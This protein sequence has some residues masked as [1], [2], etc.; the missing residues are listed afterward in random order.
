M[1]LTREQRALVLQRISVLEAELS[2]LEGEGGGDTPVPA[3]QE[4]ETYPLQQPM[5][6]DPNAQPPK[7][8]LGEAIARG[9]A[10]GL[11][12]GGEPQVAGITSAMNP[13]AGTV[14]PFMNNPSLPPGVLL[15]GLKNKSKEQMLGDYRTT[16]DSEIAANKKAEADRPEGYIP[17]QIATSIASSAVPIAG[18]ASKAKTG[19]EALSKLI[20]GGIASGAAQGLI[21][22]EADLT[23]GEWER[24]SSDMLRGGIAG[25]LTSVAAGAA[26][27]VVARGAEKL[28]GLGGSR[29]FKAAVGPQKRAFVQTSGKDL[30][31]KAVGYLDKDLGVGWGDT[32]EKIGAKLSARAE[33]L[34][35]DLDGMVSSLDTLSGGKPLVSATR[36]AQKIENEIAAPLKRAG[37]VEEYAQVRAIARE[38][39][40]QKNLSFSDAVSRRSMMQKKANYDKLNNLGVIEKVRR[41]MARIWNDEIDEMAEPLLKNAGKAGDAYRELR[42]E[43]QLVLELLRH[44]EN[45]VSANAAASF[46]RPG[47]VVTGAVGTGAALSGHPVLGTAAII[48]SVLAK[49]YGNAAAGRTAV[50]LAKAL[51]KS[52]PSVSAATPAASR[53]LARGAADLT[54]GNEEDENRGGY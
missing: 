16:R 6:M 19:V 8:S 47:N 31:K 10:Q 11:L 39:R 2:A 40:K 34:R 44:N 54:S 32:T 1:A 49:K 45:Q 24:G 33:K 23:R 30:L 14:A 20:G 37:A 48:A 12:F 5:S 15:S 43:D 50:G 21:G 18:A 52:V 4:P 36:V 7:T 9:G 53:A 29:L 42:H 26:A 17:A 3:Q 27:P 38:I 28:A 22:S 13:P 51:E 25:G 41:D 35:G 46:Y